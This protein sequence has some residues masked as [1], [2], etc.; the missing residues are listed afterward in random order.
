MKDIL[1]LFLSAAG[2][3]AVSVASM[4]HCRSSSSG[5]AE[6]TQYVPRTRAAVTCPK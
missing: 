5:L 3:I 6:L 4:I 1:S 2:S